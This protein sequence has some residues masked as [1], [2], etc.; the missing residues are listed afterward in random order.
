MLW[1]T[2]A[3]CAEQA[4][5]PGAS[6]VSGRFFGGRWFPREGPISAA[7]LQALRCPTCVPDHR[8]G[9]VRRFLVYMLTCRPREAWHALAVVCLMYERYWWP[10]VQRFRG[11]MILPACREE[12][13][14]MFDFGF[15]NYLQHGF[16]KAR[17]HLL[18][19]P[20]AWVC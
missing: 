15:H 2:S 10:V 13:R 12:A 5:A 14:A 3:E 4:G 7:Q 9:E 11:L 6:E 19:S 20:R 1:W 8:I 17:R 16:P 18:P